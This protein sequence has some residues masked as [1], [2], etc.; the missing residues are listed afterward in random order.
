MEA[1]EA[2]SGMRRPKAKKRVNAGLRRSVTS[3][4]G[5]EPGTLSLTERCIPRGSQAERHRPH[6]PNIAGSIPAPAIHGKR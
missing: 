2:S 3:P 5:E 6:K 1:V 4:G